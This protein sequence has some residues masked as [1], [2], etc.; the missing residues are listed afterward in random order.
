MERKQVKGN[1]WCLVDK[2]LIPY[3]KLNDRQ[4]ILLDAGKSSNRESI[5]RIMEEEGLEIVG[6]V[7]THMHYD[8]NENTRYFK[9]KYHVPV[10][11]PRGEAEI[12][13]NERSLKNHLFC[14]T[15]GLIHDVERLQN[16]VCPVD[17]NIE[18][19]DTKVIVAGVSFDVIHAP[20]HSPDHILLITPDNVCYVGDAILAE[21]DLER[22]EIPFVFDMALDL[23]S[24]EKMKQLS[25]DK[26]IMAHYGIADDIIDLIEENKALIE[27]QIALFKSFISRPMNMC[28]CYEVILTHLNQAE[29]HPVWNMHMER[30]LRPYL[31]YLIDTKQVELV[32]GKGSPTLA[33][34][35]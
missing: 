34:L 9:E 19:E 13:R 31:E 28:E 15:P 5:E 27:R 35:G 24:K 23:D 3:Y 11:M 6:I 30:Y 25:C 8:H 18:T 4:C 26:Y 2:Q 1:T 12:C 10:A 22:A 14:F 21:H 16:L 32:Q 17:I 7:L 33:P 20:G 29:V